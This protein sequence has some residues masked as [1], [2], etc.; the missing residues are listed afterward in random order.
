MTTTGIGGILFRSK[1]P[2]KTKQWYKENLGFDTDAYGATFK[3]RPWDDPSKTAYIQWSP[4]SEKTNYL[5]DADQQ[6]MVNYRV[7]DLE[8]LVV[9]LKEAGVTICDEVE[10]YDYGKFVH[11]LDGDG[12]K[13]ELWEPID[14][15]FDEYYNENK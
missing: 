2:D 5:G 3:F 14:K 8:K 10:T 13:I 1:D 11:I 7:K 9:D 4:M 15:V 12:R 6:F